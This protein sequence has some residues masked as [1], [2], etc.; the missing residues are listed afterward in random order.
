MAHPRRGK[1]SSLRLRVSQHFV[2]SNLHSRIYLTL[3]FVG[4]LRD[5]RNMAR[6]VHDIIIEIC[7]KYGQM[8]ASEAQAFVKKL[9]TQRR[10]SADVW[11]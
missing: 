4:R 1:W 8:S 11:S 7:S 2:E 6:D 3:V 10:Y 5:A 9:E